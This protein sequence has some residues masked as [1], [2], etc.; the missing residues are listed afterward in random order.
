MCSSDLSDPNSTTAKFFINLDTYTNIDRISRVNGATGTG[1]TISAGTKADIHW[2]ILPAKGAAAGSATATLY[3]VGATLDYT[4]AGTRKNIVVSP[5]TIRVKPLPALVLDYFIP[6]EVFGDDPFTPTIEVPEPFNLGL[7]IANRASGAAGNLQ[8]ESAQPVIK[9]NKQG[10]AVSFDLLG[11]SVNGQAVTPNLNLN[12]GTLDAYATA[13]ARW[14]MQATLSG[15]IT[16]FTSSFTHADAL[17]G[18]LTSLLDGVFTHYL[19]HDVVVD[20]PGRD[21]VRDFLASDSS[22]LQG[23]AGVVREIGR[24]HV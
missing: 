20:L 14:N 11:S 22:I 23:N 17:G 2:F 3:Y 5:D 10:L 9:D 6:A 15:K 7:R 12:F 21:P 1:G 13:V 18:Q 24:A 4:L 16:S 8:M 19:I